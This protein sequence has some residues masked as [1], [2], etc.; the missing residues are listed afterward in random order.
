[1][2]SETTRLEAEAQVV[3]SALGASSH[4]LAKLGFDGPAYV[5]LTFPQYDGSR[6]N[7]EMPTD[8]PHWEALVRLAR[9]AP[10]Q[11]LASVKA[12]F[13]RRHSP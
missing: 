11:G 3:A 4:Q 7:F 10:E 5:R 2:S 9:K 1:M 12:S 6:Y 13:F 8:G